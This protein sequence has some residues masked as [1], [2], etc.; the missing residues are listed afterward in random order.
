MRLLV[1]ILAEVSERF[2]AGILKQILELL[3]APPP[4]R[5]IFPV[6]LTERADTRISHCAMDI[7]I[8]VSMASV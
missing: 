6:S 2:C 8:L 7:T 5:K 4:L 1:V 3:V